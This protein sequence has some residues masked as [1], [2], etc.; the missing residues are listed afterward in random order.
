MPAQS[1]KHTLWTAALLVLFAVSCTHS[2]QRRNIIENSAYRLAIDVALGG[3]HAVLEDKRSGLRLADGPLACRVDAAGMK[4]R[5][6]F[7]NWSTR[8]FRWKATG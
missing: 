5:P 2:D 4:T 6:R 7:S 1:I 8:P 3:L